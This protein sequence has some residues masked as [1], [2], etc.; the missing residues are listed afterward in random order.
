MP[1]LEQACFSGCAHIIPDATLQIRQIHPTSKIAVLV[2]QLWDFWLESSSLTILALQFRKGEGFQR[3]A[4][5]LNKLMTFNCVSK[6]V[7]GFAWLSL[8]NV[9]RQKSYKYLNQTFF[10]F[11]FCSIRG[12][13]TEHV[14]Y[15]KCH[16]K[17]YNGRAL[18]FATLGYNGILI[19]IFLEA[20]ALECILYDNWS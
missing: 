20:H 19:I 2:N 11:C 3:V 12:S 14:L 15:F 13:A 6:V 4:H 9:A 18:F 16:R 17:Y 1:C 8:K 5:S 10:L 7:P